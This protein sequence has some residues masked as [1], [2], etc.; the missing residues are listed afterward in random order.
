M[1]LF[2]RLHGNYF[3]NYTSTN[4]SNLDKLGQLRKATLKALSTTI[5]GNRALID[6]FAEEIMSYLMTLYQYEPKVNKT[7]E[8]G[9]PFLNYSSN[10]V[11]G[12]RRQ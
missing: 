7:P 11:H 2:V 9:P 6:P 5:K 12:Y 4:E 1:D 3:S 8:R 10:C